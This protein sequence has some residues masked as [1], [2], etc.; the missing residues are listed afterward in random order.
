LNILGI[1][2][3]QD[4]CQLVAK[5]QAGNWAPLGPAKALPI[6]LPQDPSEIE[7]DALL[8]TAY[9]YEMERPGSDLRA[10]LAQTRDFEEALNDFRNPNLNTTNAAAGPS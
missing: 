10:T 7:G 4:R 2:V 6:F 5:D 9:Q 3:W 8:L 1:S